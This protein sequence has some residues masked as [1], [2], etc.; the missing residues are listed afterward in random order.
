[1]SNFTPLVE[2]E[3][4]FEG[5]VIKV[6]FSRLTRKDMLAAMP[7][8]KKLNDIKSEDEKDP[9]VAEAMNELLN[10]VADN[11]PKYVKSFTGLNDADG[12]SIDIETVCSEYYFS[13]LAV[14][15]AASILLA[16]SAQEGKV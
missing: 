15:I 12:N 7:A 16:S 9:R 13:K 5:D 3:F 8:F 11:I 1:M 4:N 10:S 14:N 2:Q 6:S